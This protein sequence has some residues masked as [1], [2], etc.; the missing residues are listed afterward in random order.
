MKLN[1]FLTFISVALASLVG[2]LIFH[3][4]E[5]QANNAI[6]GI[7]STICFIATLLPTI[8]MQYEGNR[9]GTNIR[10]LSALFFIVFLISQFC[11]AGLG[12]KQPYYIIINGILLA[13]YLAICYKMLCIKDI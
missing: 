11:F 7:V 9:L 3:V 10:V 4:T 12:V 1:L 2:Y 8:G 13:L 6:Y 5:N